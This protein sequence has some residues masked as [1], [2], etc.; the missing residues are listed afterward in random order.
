MIEVVRIA[1]QD[2]LHGLAECPNCRLHL[3]A[4]KD[5]DE[6]IQTVE[7]TRAVGARMTHRRCGVSF[8]VVFG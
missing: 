8:E 3:D 1:R 6:L 5:V 4:Q 7:E 2:F